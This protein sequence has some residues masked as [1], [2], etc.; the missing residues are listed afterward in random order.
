MSRLF[1][2]F[3]AISALLCACGSENLEW[4]ASPDEMSAGST[5]SIT[6]DMNLNIS[7]SNR[8]YPQSCVAEK[9]PTGAKVLSANDA[10]F[11]VKADG[12]SDDTAALTRVIDAAKAQKYTH[13]V[14]KKATYLMNGISVPPGL[15]LM[16][17]CAT[18][19]IKDYQNGWVRLLNVPG[20]YGYVGALDAP[21][22]HIRGFTFDGQFDEAKFIPDSKHQGGVFVSGT[23]G[24]GKIKVLV[25]NS[26]FANIYGD[27]VY[28]YHNNDVVV[29]RISAANIDRCV[30]CIGGAANKLLTQNMHGFTSKTLFD[31]EPNVEDGNVANSN[32]ITLKDVDISRL[33][34]YLND[35]STFVGDRIKLVST[36]NM[37]LTS[38]GGPG[39]TAIIRNSYFE[40]TPAAAIQLKSVNK[41]T[42]FENTSIRM[43]YPNRLAESPK[44]DNAAIYVAW[45]GRDNQ[46]FEMANSKFMSGTGIKSEDLMKAIMLYAG[47]RNNNVVSLD[48]VSTDTLYD[49]SVDM[50]FGGV[51]R[52]VDST[53]ARIVPRYRDAANYLGYFYDVEVL[54]S[55]APLNV[56]TQPLSD[57]T[58]RCVIDDMVCPR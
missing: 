5:R 13:V 50:D 9:P 53:L 39:A 12:V 7:M 35:S 43:V 58:N 15:T 25:Q 24:Q 33:D 11:G 27:G 18:L 3:V 29:N 34:L 57:A 56:G 21:Q 17:N 14:F 28:L 30:V 8:Y 22:T 51:V 47:K 10:Q 49:R 41:L 2:A 40:L 20:K 36:Q 42:R 46:R 37:S 19:K 16:G 55:V 44:L 38:I 6:G 23:R 54:R 45:R 1:L 4:G 26:H 52:I 32:Q 31:I 48:R